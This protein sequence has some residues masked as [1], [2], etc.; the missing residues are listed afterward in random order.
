MVVY[1][2]GHS[3]TQ[4]SKQ[5]ALLRKYDIQIVVDVR[6]TPY[7]QY[8]PQYNRESVERELVEAGIEYMFAG[9]H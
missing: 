3:N 6:S 9:E 2:F 8:S 4:A 7:L 1:T 5:I